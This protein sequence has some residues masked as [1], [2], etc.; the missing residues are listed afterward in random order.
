VNNGSFV[1]FQEAHRQAN[2]GAGLGGDYYV[3]SDVSV[4]DLPHANV[5]TENMFEVLVKM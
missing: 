3:F 4:F 1:K 2:G 5:C